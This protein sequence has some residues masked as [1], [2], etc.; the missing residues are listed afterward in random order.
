MSKLKAALIYQDY[1]VIQ[2]QKPIHI[3]GSAEP[4]HRILTILGDEEVTSQTDSKG[5][6][7]VLFPP[8]EAALDVSLSIRDL[9][10]GETLDYRHLAIGEVWIGGGQSNMEFL[11]EFDDDR[12]LE[13]SRP[14][15]DAVR[16]FE[17]PRLA[18][19]GDPLDVSDMGI[20]RLCRADQL[21]HFSGVGYYFGR[22][23]EETLKVPVGI[24]GCSWG[25]T[26]ALTWMPRERIRSHSDLRK[27]WDMYEREIENL[28]EDQYESDF[29]RIRTIMNE[30]KQ[31]AHHQIQHW[32]SRE[33]QLAF[34]R[35]QDLEKYGLFPS[36][37]MGPWHQNAP[38]RLWESMVSTIGGMGVRG[39]LWYQG[40]SDI[41][42]NEDYHLLLSAVIESWRNLWGEELPWLFV[43][44]APF[45]KWLDQNGSLF[46][47]IRRRQE[48][49]SQTTPAAWMVSTTDC[50]LKWGIHPTRKKPIGKRLSL[51][52]RGKVYKEDI[53][54]Q[55]PRCIKAIRTANQIRLVF[56]HA[57]D[58]MELHDEI[59]NDL[60]VVGD[61]FKREVREL[62]CR[63]DSV[64]LSL[65][66]ESDPLFP[67]VNFVE[68]LNLPYG[69]SVLYNS[70]GLPA[71]PF[72]VEVSEE[73]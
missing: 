35:E 48:L 1:C 3:W 25:G 40:E 15:N 66:D 60:Y 58:G 55:S 33:D 54:C 38:G 27:Y 7:S 4:G 9:M 24:V 21:I 23:L 8:R 69:E 14:A 49:V 72:V 31:D 67:P 65:G 71:F 19:A 63:G 17:V 32:I 56:L 68:F 16:Y 53:L 62:T 30:R 44:L 37:P 43:Q 61:G 36:L 52:A 12:Y 57:G 2:R 22:D 45:Y 39:I 10:S 6:W 26:S 5:S 64:I 11:M 42:R 73:C 29:F 50:G 41:G 34:V 59:Q 18:F 13:L 70:G 20:W 47:L 28:D 51:L 46:P